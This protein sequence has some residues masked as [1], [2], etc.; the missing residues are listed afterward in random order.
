MATLNCEW[1]AKHFLDY[2]VVSITRKFKCKVGSWVSI[3]CGFIRPSNKLS[4]MTQ[5]AVYQT[6]GLELADL[7]A[8]Y[9]AEP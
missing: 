6:V 7:P 3:R 8:E 2:D 1:L 4:T 9:L 5:L